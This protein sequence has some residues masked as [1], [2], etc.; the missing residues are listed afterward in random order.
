MTNRNYSV[1]RNPIEGKIKSPRFERVL[2]ANMNWWDPKGG[3]LSKSQFK[4][5][6]SSRSDAQDQAAV[7]PKEGE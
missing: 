4:G 3:S 6:V 5:C 7:S 1:D 2:A